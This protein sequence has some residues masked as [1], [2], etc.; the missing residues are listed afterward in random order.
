MNF[1]MDA[2]EFGRTMD[3]LIASGVIPEEA[4][5]AD[6]ETIE[7]VMRFITLHAKNAGKE[8]T[9][10]NVTYNKKKG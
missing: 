9:I 10:D 4:N 6:P 3:K 5:M 7:T 8:V 1:M 2:A